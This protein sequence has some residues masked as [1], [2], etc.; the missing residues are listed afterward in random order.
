MFTEQ[1]DESF[2]DIFFEHHLLADTAS[3]CSFVPVIHS[4]SVHHNTFCFSCSS[5]T[6]PKSSLT[7]RGGACINVFASVSSSHVVIYV[8]LKSFHEVLLGC[9]LC[10]FSSL[11]LRSTHLLSPME[12]TAFCSSSSSSPHSVSRGLSSLCFVVLHAF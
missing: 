1:N 5:F 12:P 2:Y 6:Y 4:A 7:S 10:L 3:S 8:V 11:K 9:V